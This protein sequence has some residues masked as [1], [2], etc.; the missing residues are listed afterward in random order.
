LRFERDRNNEG[1][2]FLLE[3]LEHTCYL[4]SSLY[5]HCGKYWLVYSNI[6]VAEFLVRDILQSMCVAGWLGTITP[7]SA[8]AVLTV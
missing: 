6:Q 2:G 8:N 5:H 4:D 3:V 1:C 7:G